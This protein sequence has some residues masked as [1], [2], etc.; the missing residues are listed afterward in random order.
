MEI[1]PSFVEGAVS[2][3]EDGVFAPLCACGCV[4]LVEGVSLAGA[5]SDA[6]LCQG[7]VDIVFLVEAHGCREKV[8][9]VLILDVC[10]LRVARR[11]ESGNTGSMTVPFVTPELT[12]VAVQSEPELVHCIQG[13]GGLR[14]RRRAK[15]GSDVVVVSRRVAVL[16]KST[17]AGVRPETVNCPC[18]RGTDGRRKV[19]ELRE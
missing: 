12:I 10:G 4:K 18:V 13:V 5:R 19:P 2:A 11:G 16:V 6:C 7:M 8:D 17:I 14:R 1:H 15:N 3:S 9:N